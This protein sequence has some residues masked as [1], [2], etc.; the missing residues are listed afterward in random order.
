MEENKMIPLE[1]PIYPFEGALC[2]FKNSKE[3]ILGCII[4]D[5]DNWHIQEYPSK[6]QI[7]IN[8]FKYYQYVLNEKGG[9]HNIA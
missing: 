6:K 4:M 7:K 9:F 3:M 1:L 8:N 5:N 2:M